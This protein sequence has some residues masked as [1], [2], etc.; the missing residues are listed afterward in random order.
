MA[1]KEVADPFDILEGLRRTCVRRGILKVL[2][3]HERWQQDEL[4]KALRDPLDMITK[5]A[6]PIS[7]IVG[8][9]T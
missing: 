6:S 7:P 5:P 1:I 9:T 3:D 4:Q 2:P 8:V